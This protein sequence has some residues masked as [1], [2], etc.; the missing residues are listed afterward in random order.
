MIEALASQKTDS[1]LASNEP[2]QHSGSQNLEPVQSFLTCHDPVP[3][4]EEFRLPD[5]DFDEDIF[6]SSDLT[7]VGSS[8][9]RSLKKHSFLDP[10]AP[11]SLSSPLRRAP[12][13][14]L[15]S[16]RLLSDR[17]TAL[18]KAS[19][20][21]AEEVIDWPTLPVRSTD[22]K[23]RLFTGSKGV[24]KSR[25]A[26]IKSFALRSPSK[27]S[28]VRVTTHAAPARRKLTVYHPPP[29]EKKPPDST[30]SRSL[31]MV[32]AHQITDEERLERL[33][34]RAARQDVSVS[35]SENRV[36]FAQTAETTVPSRP[37]TQS[38]SPPPYSCDI[39]KIAQTYPVKRQ[40]LSEVQSVK[41][42]LM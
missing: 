10:V 41:L 20:L 3:N 18:R 1:R 12:L 17:Q 27:L 13:S 40:V 11:R 42:S 30:D 33:L 22:S 37:S 5:D 24:T 28:G 25:P 2:Q 9:V 39:G 14:P 36:R 38:L 6:P 4:A 23:S 15:P 19:E 29:R 32:K 26:S 16:T 34:A 8:P 21:K 7:L 35:D 31:K